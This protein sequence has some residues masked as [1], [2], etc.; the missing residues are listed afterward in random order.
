MTIK[1]TIISLYPSPFD[2]QIRHEYNASIFKNGDLFSYEEGKL[3]SIKNDGIGI[4]P[5]RSLFYGLKELKLDIKKVSKWVFPKTKKKISEEEFYN[6]FNLLCK[7]YTGKKSNFNK[8]LKKKVNFV[9]H[10]D[11]HIYNAFG[12]S[13]FSNSFYFSSD[14]GGDLGD[15]RNSSWGTIKNFTIKENGNAFGKNGISTFHAF[16][17][18]ACGFRNENGKLSGLSSYGKINKELYKKFNNLITVSKKGIF[19][20]RQ[21]YNITKP[22]FNIVNVDSYDRNKILNFKISSTNVLKICKKY[23]LEDIAATAEEVVCDN[24]LLFLKII[25]NKSFK[26]INNA[27]FTGGLFLNIKLNEKI[28]QSKIFKKCYFTM[29]PSDSGLSLGGIFSEKVKLN[30]KYYSK[31]GLTP[32][33][34]PS[35]KNNQILL[36]AKSHSLRAK[37][38]SNKIITKDIAK[39]LSKGKI[40]GLFNGKA[41]YGQ[42]SLGARS[43]LADP[44]KKG[45]KSKINLLLKKR[46]WFMPFAPA[47]LDKY[48]NDYFKDSI[49][50]LYMQKA[51][52]INTSKIKQIKAGVHVDN[53][54]RIQFVEKKLN[55]YFWNIINEFRKKTG[56][57]CILNTSFNRHGISTISTPR[58]AIEHFMENCFD[59]L[60]FNNLKI[61]KKE[62]QNIKLQNTLTSEKKLLIKENKNWSKKIFN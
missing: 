4:F 6:F 15:E 28:E 53:T 11:L 39:E 62:K 14:G 42:R 44:A 5:E 16:V 43:I 1:K 41:E 23:K 21:R 26:K 59:I 18:E 45:V 22:D 10:H 40:V 19:F 24:V 29:A 20:N 51:Q 34:G 30:K 17:T 36:L 33:L 49:P 7:A 37:K 9:R 12:S 52:K 13:G 27:I 38:Y 25:K 35:F 57:P 31:Y 56:I 2:N 48:Y 55:K 54:C 50:S 46:D 58:Q 61:E 3:S 47:I 60:Y 32:Y 8:W